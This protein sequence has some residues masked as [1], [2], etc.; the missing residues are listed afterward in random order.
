MTRSKLIYLFI[1]LLSV[2]LATQANIVGVDGQ[3]FAPLTSGLDFVTVNS[4]RTLKKGRLNLGLFGD[5]SSGNMPTYQGDE[6]DVD[7]IGNYHFHIGL[8]L[9]KRLDVGFSYDAVFTASVDEK[10]AWRGFIEEEGL[11][12]YQFN[13]RYRFVEGEKYG[14]AL[15]VTYTMFKLKNN[16]FMGQTNEPALAF[17]LA[18]DKHFGRKIFGANIGYRMRD[19]TTPVPLTSTNNNRAIRPMDDQILISLALAHKFK[20]DKT[21]LIGEIYGALAT[22]DSLFVNTAAPTGKDGQ[23]KGELNILEVLLGVRHDVRETLAL[24]AGISAGPMKKSFDPT[25]RVYAGLNW[26]FDLWGK[27]DKSH[28]IDEPAPVAYE[29]VPVTTYPEMPEIQQEIV[30]TVVEAPFQAT[31]ETASEVVYTFD[32]VHFKTSSAKIPQ[33]FR[34][35]LD[36]FAT[37]LNKIDYQH[38]DVVGH[39][40]SRGSAASNRALSLSRAK[41]V[42]L[43]LINHW[44]IPSNKISAYGRGEDQPIATNGTRDGMAKNRRVEFVIKKLGGDTVTSQTGTYYPEGSGAVTY[45][46]G[47][48]SYSG[49]SS[50]TTNY[51]GN[52]YGLQPSKVSGNMVEFTFENLNFATNS[53]VLPRAFKEK[54]TMLVEYLNA[55]P[56]SKLEVNGHTDSRGDKY[57]N[58]DLSQRR[59]DSARN[60]LVNDWF[61]DSSKIVT[62]GFGE[63]RPIGSNKT[64]SGRAK[65][66]R[67][68]FRVYKQ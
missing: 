23:E 28:V 27:G 9:L 59:A 36:Q 2:P 68:V 20:N 41:N 26:Y 21:N 43:A 22:K 66:R 52:Y 15:I 16:P 4:T 48:T 61:Q 58:Q 31:S 46:G 8:G 53:A 34:G 40:D 49:G 11:M 39:T 32:N 65:N 5:Y 60:A 38:I 37:Y 30:E 17:E 29:E 64:R 62:K 44:G 3:N 24:H 35:E 50:T 12:G 57:Y 33:S 63:M 55:T 45:D 51:S 10:K 56:Y 67:V 54:L 47:S 1:F 19:Q 13:A 14:L 25:W 6:A 7:T 18:F 42:R